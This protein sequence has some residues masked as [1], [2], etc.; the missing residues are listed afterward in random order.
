MR[1]STPTGHSLKPVL[2]LEHDFRGKPPPT[3]PHHAPA[4][5]P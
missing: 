4:F 5:M 2:L 1:S 3:F